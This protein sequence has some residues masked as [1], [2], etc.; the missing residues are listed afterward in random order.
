[1]SKKLLFIPHSESSLTNIF[2]VINF[3]RKLP[4]KSLLKP[5]KGNQR[6]I[7][8]QREFHSFII[9]TL[10]ISNIYFR[11]HKKF[12]IKVFDTKI[13]ICPNFPFFKVNRFTSVKLLYFLLINSLGHGNF[14]V[15]FYHY[16]YHHP[17]HCP[18]FLP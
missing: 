1:M 17:H 18:S 11:R 10:V 6:N 15:A 8:P 5:P 4:I 2:I 9:Q 13:Y 7:Q 14:F 16:N 12:T 3:L